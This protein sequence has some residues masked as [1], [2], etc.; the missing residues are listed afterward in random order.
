MFV[1]FYLGEQSKNLGGSCRPTSVATCL[2]C[3]VRELTEKSRE[4]KVIFE[5]SSKI[6]RVLCIFVAKKLYL[7][8][9]TRTMG[10]NRPPGGEDV[11][12]KEGG[13]NLAGGF[14]PRQLARCYVVN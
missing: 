14:N 1:R 10:L 7:W 11:K 8:P 6:C 12:R 5:F 2:Y 9:E 13:D 3:R 4:R